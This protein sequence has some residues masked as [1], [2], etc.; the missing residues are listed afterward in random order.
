M[1]LK[2]YI[3]IKGA[4]HT[5]KYEEVPERGIKY[6]KGKKNKDVAEILVTTTL[7]DGKEYTFQGDEMSQ[8]RLHRAYTLLVAK[9]IPTIIWKTSNNKVVDLTAD[10]VLDI[11]Y[12]AATVQ[13]EL[14]FN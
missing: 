5:P 7:A 3:K 11:L 4:L 12:Q 1:K 6:T 14:W 9:S 13:T 10:E 8:T 2:K